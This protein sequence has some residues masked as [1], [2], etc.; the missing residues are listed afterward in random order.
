M[1]FRIYDCDFGVKINGV[2]YDFEHVA[3]LKIE[4]PEK[5]KLTRGS[6]AGNRI[7]LAYKEGMKEPKT[8]TIPI[9]NMSAELKNVLDQAFE[10]QDRCDVYCIS[11][12]DGS[13]KMAKNAIL[14]NRPQQ[15]SIDDSAESMNVELM[16]ETFD[17]SESHKS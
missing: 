3:E 17:S 8:W 9:L 6:N 2:S 10:N 16:F 4:D 7:G 13:S 14:S 11:R 15:L 1:I 5:N 12:A